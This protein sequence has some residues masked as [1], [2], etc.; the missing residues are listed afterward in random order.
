M[1]GEIIATQSLS[2]GLETPVTVTVTNPSS[3]RLEFGV[4]FTLKNGFEEEQLP[5]NF[6]FIV[7]NSDIAVKFRCRTL[8]S[9]ITRSTSE[10]VRVSEVEKWRLGKKISKIDTYLRTQLQDSMEEEREWE[11]MDLD[12]LAFNNVIT[13]Q[14]LDF[15]AKWEMVAF[16]NENLSCLLLLMGFDDGN[17]SC[18]VC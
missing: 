1:E 15:V 13:F 2:E 9:V 4:I 16:Y 8:V 12:F 6:L 11:D 18:D 17:L 10:G 14:S 5:K 7:L 3:D